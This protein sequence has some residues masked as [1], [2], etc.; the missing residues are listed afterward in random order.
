MSSVKRLTLAAFGV[1]LLAL[2]LAT[3]PAHAQV[4][5]IP[6]VGLVGGNMRVPGTG[7]TLNPYNYYD[8]YGYSRQAAFNIALYGRA[9]SQVPPYAL[10]Y[11]PYASIVNTPYYPTYGGYGGYGGYGSLVNNP[12]AYTSPGI[13][14]PG[15]GGGYGDQG[16]NNGYLPYYDPF[17]GYLQ[18]A[19][20]VMQAEGKFRINNQ[21][22]NL[23][24]EQVRSAHIDNNRKAFDE[25]LYER[26][27]RPTWLDDLERQNK[28]NLRAAVTNPSG[29]EIL[30][31]VTLNILLENLKQLRA[32][33]VKGND[34]PLTDDL[35]K[36]I[37]V[38]AGGGAN[39]GL[40]KNEHLSWPLGL[41]GTEF[42]K[43]RK[44]IERNLATAVS[45]VEHA[46]VDPARLRDLADAV[47]RMSEDLASP[48]QINEMTPSQYIEARNY[49]RLLND[50]IKSLS[51]PDAIKYINN[52]YAAKG[53][54]VGELIDSMSG[55]RF[56]P[57]TPGDEQAYRAL[58]DKL[59]K[60]YIG[61]TAGSGSS[62]EQ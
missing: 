55:L 41:S 37:N 42:E 62:R 13:A 57:A 44:K 34:V 24:R 31:G 61:A 39:P 29:G 5:I 11:N 22:A 47:D 59:V 1:A 21:Q 54:N 38:T 45:E 53:K 18:G 10:G 48:T 3:A 33:G 43:D 50:A 46:K 35:L 51:K 30:D 49:L 6:G 60:Y 58:H 27:N 15:Y 17:S 23:L 14:S 25:F 8:P 19:A 7:G 52:Q 26:A 56:A 32:K 9:M 12:A 36:Q 2:V 16:Y 4:R 40:L 20:S 28:L